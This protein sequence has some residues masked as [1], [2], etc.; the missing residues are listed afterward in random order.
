MRILVAGVSG[1]AGQHPA[2]T[3]LRRGHEV[4][5]T[6]LDELVVPAGTEGRT[7]LYRLDLAA[8]RNRIDDDLRAA[9]AAFRPQ[10]IVP[11]AARARG[12]R[13]WQETAAYER[14]NVEGTQAVLDAAGDVPVLFTSSAEVYGPVPEE[15]QP[16]AETRP[17]APASPYG[18]TKAEGERLGGG[19]AAG[20]GGVVAAPLNFIAAG[21]AR[22]FALPTFARQLAAIE[23]GQQPPTLAVGNLDARRAFV[24]V[25]DGAEALAL[26]AER[27][28]AGG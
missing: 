15:E 4:A 23:A 3:L 24:P 10:R 7:E 20:R 8:D 19:W 2:R 12:G 25:P 17:P 27:G 21:Q 22:S 26:L 18:R 5:G 11:L 9:M 28:E 16:I 6:C 14:V 1:L 13:G